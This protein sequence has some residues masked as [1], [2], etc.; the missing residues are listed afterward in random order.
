VRTTDFSTLDKLTP[1][2]AELPMPVLVAWGDH[3][4]VMPVEHG[5]RLAELVPDGRYEE[6]PDTRVITPLDAPA[7]LSELIRSFVD[8]GVPTRTHAT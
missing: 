3:G 5:R 2:L 1:Q 6:I 8:A 4:R 7:R